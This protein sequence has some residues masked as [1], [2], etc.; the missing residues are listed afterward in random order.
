[1]N[2]ALKQFSEQLALDLKGKFSSEKT[3]EFIKNVKASGDDRTFEVVMSTSDEDRQGD[4]LD[5]SKWDLKYFEMNPVVLWAHDYSSFPIGVVEDIRIEGDQAIATGKFAPVGVN[6]EA[7]MACA[8]Y[9]EKILKTV[10]PGYIQNDD[11][12]RELLEMSFCPVPAGRYA[13]SLRQVGR[14]GVSTRD[15][16]TKGFFYEEKKEKSPHGGEACELEDGTPGTLAEDPKDPGRLVCVP[17]EQKEIKTNEP[18][19]ELEKKLKA[20]HERHGEAIGKAIDEFEEKALPDEE[21]KEESREGADNSETDKAID[22]FEEK[23]DGEHETH[24]EKCMKAIDDTYETMGRK[25]NEEKSIDEFK[26][27]IK[28]EHL[29]HVKK[30]DKAIDEFKGEFPHDGAVDEKRKAIDEFTKTID[31]ELDRHEKAHKELCE[32]EAEQMG[33]GEEDGKKKGL[34]EETFM[35]GAEEREKQERMSYV[36]TVMYAFCNAYYESPVESFFELVTEAVGLIEQYA[37]DEKDG[38]PDEKK[39]AGRVAEFVKKGKTKAGRAISAKT[40]EKIKAI[41]KMIEDGHTEHWK[42]VDDVTAAL[43]AIMASGDGGEEP[44]PDEK[45]G[46]APKIK[47]EHL[48]SNSDLEVYLFNQRLARQVK[49]AAEGVLRQINPKIKELTSHGR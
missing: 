28:A 19:N 42:A 37:E 34:V 16:V 38:E 32:K 12:T 8:L 2:E 20:E 18:M 36:M 49:T 26:S 10:S 3:A 47:V 44:K 27:E 5:Q 29:E 45:S 40:K 15:L 6:P 23:M 22:E 43:K 35:Q 46:A 41:I 13:L 17:S 21:K 48:G 31:G 14:L 7:D 30:C 11:G 33:E 9:Q 1:M 24:L 25:P 4:A 39:Y